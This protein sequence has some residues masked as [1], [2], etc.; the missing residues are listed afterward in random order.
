MGP[1]KLSIVAPGYNE[2][3]GL[4][5]FHGRVSRV[6]E[7]AGYDYEIL[8]VNDGSADGSLAVMRRLRAE[9]PRVKILDFS[10]NFGHQIA[11]K[12]GIDHAAGDA[13]VVIDSDLQDPPEAI[14]DLVAKWKEGYEVVYAV[15][16]AREGESAMKKLT[17]SIYYRLLRSIGEVDLPLDAGDFRLLSRP[18]VDA[19]KPIQEKNPYI[20]GLVSWVGFRQTGVT[21]RRDARFAGETKYPLSKMLKLAW[22]GITH[23]SFLPLH[24]ATYVGF[25]A[26]ALCLLWIAQALWVRFVLDITVPGWTSLMVAVLFMGGVQLITLGIMGSYLARNYDQTRPRPLYIL[27]VKEGV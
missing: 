21:I 4:A 1:L 15:R 22:N 12:A 10:R 19:L 13:V 17:A 25:A 3:A 8:Y 9:N 11:V 5:E 23:F 6:L 14:P 2:E 24:L 20:R 16:E 18:V 26:S 27:R 7:A